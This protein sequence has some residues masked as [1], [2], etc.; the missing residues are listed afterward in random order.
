MPADLRIIRTSRLEINEVILTGEP[1]GV[2]KSNKPI[3]VPSRKLQLNRCRG[4]AFMG[5]M[6]TRGTG[7]G[8]VVRTGVDTEIGKIGAALNNQPVDAKPSPLQRQMTKLGKVLV[9]LAVF[10]CVVVFVIGMM[11]RGQDFKAMIRL[12]VSLAVS[13]IPEGLVAIM[14]VGM[15][16]AVRRLS[17][18]NVLIRRLDAVDTLGCTSVIA[19]DKT[20]TLTEGRMRMEDLWT[21]PT[22]DLKE[23]RGGMMTEE[24]QWALK[25]CIICNN[26]TINGVGEPTEVALMEGAVGRGLDA[27]GILSVWQRRLEIPFDSERRMMTVLAVPDSPDESPETSTVA[28]VKGA[29]EAVLSRCTTVMVDGRYARLDGRTNELIGQMENEYSDKGLRVLALAI[30]MEIDWSK[31]PI[32]EIAEELSSPTTAATSREVDNGTSTDWIERDLTFI[33]LVCLLDP[34]R[35]GVADAITTLHKAGIKFCMITGD[36]IRTAMAV[37]GQIGIYRKGDQMLGRAMKGTDLDL[38][39]VDA[40][41]SLQPFPSVF[42]RVSPSNK[43]AIVQ[44]LQLREEKV[45]MTGD[46]VNDAPAVRCADVG[47]AMGRGGTQITREAASLVLLDDNLANMVSAVA[48]GR[49]MYRNVT[50]FLIYLL[51]CNS[52]EIWTVLGAM[53]LGLEPPLH[54][55]ALLWANVIADIPPSMC[56]GLERDAEGGDLMTERPDRVE[57]TTMGWATWILIIVNGAV[58]SG[59]TL[60]AYGLS[61]ADGWGQRRSEAFLILIGLQLLLA[62]LSRSPRQSLFHKGIF[63]NRWLVA[64]VI[65]SFGLLLA[66]LNVPLLHQMLELEPVGWLVWAKFGIAAICMVIFNELAKFMI[67]HFGL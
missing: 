41:A 48:E 14:T 20:G 28:F 49:Q 47:V 1:I 59:V 56:L 7:L 32:S 25:V 38:L 31:A 53:I 35:E 15:A 42:A 30:R 4:N 45:A 10:L 60:L 11:W 66:G 34:P 37:A 55:M 52:A 29:A 54:P 46:G 13:V 43:L 23:A 18:R 67:R 39:S 19:A 21:L 27:V 57:K 16:L 17:K 24:R 12:S 2:S 26:A 8:V 50:L 51:S 5:T 40:L 61:H 44:A 65:F 63:G 33:G 3:R 58:L 36:H 6:V 22:S 9:I 62:L 64:A